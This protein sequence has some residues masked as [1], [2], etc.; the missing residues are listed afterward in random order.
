MAET[1]IYNEFTLEYKVFGDGPEYLI[2]FH[3]MGREADDFKIF[4]KTIG[5][6][7][8]IVAVNLFHHGNSI[9]PEARLFRNQLTKKEFVA[10][11]E[12]LL[13]KLKVDRFTLMGYSLGG[14]VALTCLQLLYK[15]VDRIILI[16]PDGLKISYYNQWVTRTSMGKNFMKGVVKYPDVFFDRVERLNKIK[17]INNRSMR[18]INFHFETHEKRILMRNVIST[19]KKIIPNLNQVVRHINKHQIEVLL[20]F[21]KHDFI[22]PVQLGKRFLSR[23]KTNKKMHI[24]DASHNILTENASKQLSDLIE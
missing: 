9:Y 14:R 1:I 13:A 4:E 21:G 6:K 23:L 7:Y 10:L 22:I 12:K 18:N 20:I 15:R 5:H 19:F 16:A 3:G 17:L 24:I 11:I 8:S 2:A